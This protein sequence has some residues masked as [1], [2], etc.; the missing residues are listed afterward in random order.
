M[1]QHHCFR[2]LF[3]VFFFGLLSMMFGY[4][5]F[6]SGDGETDKEANSYATSVDGGPNAPGDGGF[7]E[8]MDMTVDLAVDE[9]ES[10]DVDLY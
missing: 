9:P 5:C 1:T 3:F 8:W 7:E 10:N 2:S 4:G 6:I